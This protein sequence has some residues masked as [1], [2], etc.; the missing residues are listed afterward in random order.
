MKI[1]AK[2]RGAFMPQRNTGHVFI[3]ITI[4]Y[5]PE[6]TNERMSIF[7]R[8]H[9]SATLLHTQP[10]SR[11]KIIV[12]K[13]I[14]LEVFIFSLNPLPHTISIAI[15]HHSMDAMHGTDIPIQIYN[16]I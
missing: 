2:T 4:I 1:D 14:A 13:N 12:A 6:E 7:V 15:S 8:V 9:A 11:T 5:T 3:P 16:K 10:F